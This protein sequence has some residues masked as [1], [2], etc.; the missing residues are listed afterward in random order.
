MKN[1]IFSAIV[2]FA[3]A[4]AIA[5]GHADFAGHGTAVATDTKTIEATSGTHVQQT[6]LAMCG[7]MIILQK[8][9]TKR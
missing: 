9:S 5:G 6:S 8:G 7:F 1:I 4:M 2:G 3:P